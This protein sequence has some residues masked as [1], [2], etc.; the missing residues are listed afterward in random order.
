MIAFGIASEPLLAARI[1]RLTT[2]PA[3]IVLVD[4]TLDPGAPPPD[5][6]AATAATSVVDAFPGP[7]Q[8][9]AEVMVWSVRGLM[10]A[11]PPTPAL[12]DLFPGLRCKT[13]RTVPMRRVADLADSLRDRPAPITV[14]IDMPGSEAELLGQL[15]ATGLGQ[16][17]R[18]IRV[19]STSEVFF[20]GGTTAAEL[21]AQM[22]AQGF[23]LAGRDD[24]DPD[25][26]D[27]SFEIDHRA[28]RAEAL[29]AEL[30]G[31]LQAR[32]E[33]A[34]DL[35][36]QL[37]E[38]ENELRAAI[39]AHGATETQLRDELTARDG[40]VTE[41]ENELRAATEAHGA[42]ETQLRDE[43][44]ARDGRVTELESEL[45]AAAEA[46]GATQT[47]LRDELTARDGRVTELENELRAA[48]E[49]QGATETQLRD[50]VSVLKATLRAT[51]EERDTLRGEQGFTA[52]LQAMHQLDLDNLR[53]RLET[54][55]TQRQRQEALLR[56]LTAKLA[57]A[58]EYLEDLRLAEPQTVS[59]IAA[60][61]TSTPQE[62]TSGRPAR[63]TSRPTPAPRASRAR[64]KSR[65]GPETGAGE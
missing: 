10:S 60:P 3:Q 43:L 7:S 21:I 33:A 61:G 27:L 18:A 29:E 52:R 19:R 5:L 63:K 24:D 14:W 12:T 45:R 26:P 37:T 9:E 57:Q 35:S 62:Q 51:E 40:R 1:A 15:L 30:Q 54:S 6:L 64:A 44:T 42:T 38:L 28:L 53:T 55:E 49:A 65:A 13:R 56:K 34:L 17:I 36:S 50:E 47:Q 59:E 41:L 48:A 25:F 20:E 23:N 22:A 31:V 2:C 8:G 46:H 39:E 16:D 11:R 58:A 4:P 32:H